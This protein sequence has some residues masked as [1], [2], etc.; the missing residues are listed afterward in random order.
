MYQLA[1]GALFKNEAG[2]LKEWLDHYIAR[3]VQ[4]FYLINDGSTDNFM[5]VLDAYIARGYITLFHGDKIYYNGRQKDYYNDYI[6]PHIGETEWLIV[7]DIDEYIWSPKMVNLYALLR[8]KFS[9]MAQI[10]IVHTLFGSNGHEEQPSS[11]V[12]GF[13]RR[14]ADLPSAIFSPKYIVNSSYGISS[15]NVHHAT[16]TNS[17]DALYRFKIFSSE[18]LRMNHYSCQSRSFWRDVKC[19]R[20]DVDNFRNRG[21]DDHFWKEIDL[22]DVEDLGLYEQNRSLG[23]C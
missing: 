4:H 22:N 1:V 18:W 17:E 15:L 8:F 10:Q 7:V 2:G 20:G 9:D 14:S 21:V 12:G 11:I 23:L 5:E 19:K 3:G 13:T 16:L 6:L